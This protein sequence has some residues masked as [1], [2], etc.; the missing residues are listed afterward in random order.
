MR[1]LLITSLDKFGLAVPG[2]VGSD[3]RIGGSLTKP[4][5]DSTY[6]ALKLVRVLNRTLLAGLER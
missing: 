4:D 5:S 6:S 1:L 2:G 3:S